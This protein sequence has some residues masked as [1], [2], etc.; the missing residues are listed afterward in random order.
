VVPPIQL[1]A[2]DLDGTLLDPSEA[3]SPANRSA[4]ARA[5]ALGVRVVLVTGRG[6]DIPLKIARELG[7]SDPLICAHGALTKDVRTGRDVQRIAVPREWAVPMIGFAHEQ[8][9]DVAVY[10]DEHFHRPA[11]GPPHMD[12]M[13]GPHWIEVPSLL[14]LA[15][16]APTF[17]RFFGHVSVNAVTARFA[18]A[19]VHFKRETWGDF[20]ELAVT[21]E[22]ATKQRAL[23]QLC[24]RLRV[25]AET[26]LAIG[27]SRND[28]PEV[29]DAV[30]YV[31]D[32]NDEDGV[33]RAIERFVLGPPER[34]ERSA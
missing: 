17:L 1:V 15:E 32:R 20:E 23:A 24:R 19:R 29:I 13:R 5:R 2:L 31:T 25:D 3:I 7:L 11:G 26:V 9:L 22:E 34:E 27:D 6:S 18:N 4:I 16:R 28:V 8:R 30:D 10:I 14:A 21:S 33:A 12:D